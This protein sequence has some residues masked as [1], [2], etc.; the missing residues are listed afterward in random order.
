MISFGKEICTSRSMK[1][2]DYPQLY[3]NLAE[4]DPTDSI[5]AV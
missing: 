4:V 3:E 1:C 5:D 2:H